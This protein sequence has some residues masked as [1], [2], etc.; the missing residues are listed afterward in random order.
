MASTDRPTVPLLDL[1]PLH[2]PLRAEINAAVKSVMDS[3][4]FVLGEAVSRFEDNAARY[5]GARHAVGVASGTDALLLS[6]KA[7]GIGRGDE[8]ITTAFTFF[9]TVEA[10]L[11]AGATPVFVDIE[12]DS[13]MMDPA[14]I[15]SRITAATRAIMP[16]HLYG[17]A[18]DMHEILAIAKHHGLEVIEDV[19]QAYG[20]TLDGTSAGCFGLTG[21]FSFHPTK[22]LG[23]FGDGGLVITDNDDIASALRQLRDHGSAARYHHT[24][25]GYN[26]RLDS[27]Q[28]AV[29]DV[30]LKHLD[31]H[32]SARNRLAENYRQ[33]L[34]GLPLTLPT[35]LPNRRHCHAQYTIRVA[36]RDRVRTALAEG[37]IGSA[38]HYPTPIYRQPA[39]QSTM[40]D[41]FGADYRL[42]VT[43]EVSDSCLSLPLFEGLTE[44]QQQRVAEVLADALGNNAV[45]IARG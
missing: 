18:C 33:L 39:I 19:A 42:P 17:Q 44:Q 14:Q 11:H 12:P 26:S 3:N 8:I 13:M 6:L 35:A 1:E 38:V 21:C 23:A 37:G 30:K 4:A 24:S 9:G 31:A 41:H 20:A 36:N 40:A 16:V 32:L 15:E 27:I 34:D 45:K 28:A 25:V 10:I 7:A 2:A 22:P 5:L 43:E 29:L